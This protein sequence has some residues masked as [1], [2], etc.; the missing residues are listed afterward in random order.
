MALNQLRRA[1]LGV[2]RTAPVG[3]VAAESGLTPARALLD[4]W[5]VRFA[6][7][8]MAR[9]RGGGGQE[10]I[11]ERRISAL[12]ARTRERSRLGR[13]ETV[14]EQRWDALRMFQGKVFV[15]VFDAEVFAI[16]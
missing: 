9:S 1:S 11:L 10:G 14:E 4:H 6:L 13:W 7:S 5:Q 16:L 8:L 3:I 2:R 12:T 15:E